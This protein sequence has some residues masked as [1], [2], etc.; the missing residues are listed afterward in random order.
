MVCGL[1]S[2]RHFEGACT[3]GGRS[4]GAQI[5]T[6]QLIA[7]SASILPNQKKSAVLATARQDRRQICAN[8]R[9]LRIKKYPSSRDERKRSENYDFQRVSDYGKSLWPVLVSLL[10]GDDGR[11]PL[12]AGAKELDEQ[13]GAELSRG[14]SRACRARGIWACTRFDGWGLEK[15]DGHYLAASILARNASA[16]CQ[17]TL[18]EPSL[19]L[20]LL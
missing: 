17:A 9:N 12:V 4:I 20:F 16:L 10:D 18:S 3:Q 19:A 15:A 7:T 11:N 5:P 8:L 6:L 2:E 13:V 1:P 14:D